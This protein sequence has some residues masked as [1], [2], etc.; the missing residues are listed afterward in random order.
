MTS[1]GSSKGYGTIFKITPSG[2][3]SVLHEFNSPTEGSNAQGSLVQGTDKNLYG[4]T[5]AGGSNGTGTI[6]KITLT[7][8]FTLL[9]SFVYASE[10]ANPEGS[11][12]QAKDG[13]FYGLTTNSPRASKSR[14]A[15]LSACCT[16]STATLKDLQLSEVLYKELTE[17]FM[18]QQARAALMVQEQSLK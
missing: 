13:N 10:G 3:Y 4:M 2:N 7:G 14:P 18:Q 5:N 17:I 9:H 1:E 12:I 6:F 15:V 8:T 11:L 16:L